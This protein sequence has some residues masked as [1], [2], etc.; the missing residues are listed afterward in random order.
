VKSISTLRTS[1]NQ[2]FASRGYPIA[3]QA[4]PGEYFYSPFAPLTRTLWRLSLGLGYRFSDNLVL[5]TEYSFEGGRELG[6]DARDHEDLFA[7]QA[8]LKF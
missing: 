1:H 6:G 5:K 2:I 3:G 7:V 8:A 4:D